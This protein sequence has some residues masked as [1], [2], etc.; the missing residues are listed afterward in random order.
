[1]VN[2]LGVILIIITILYVVFRLSK[3]AMT[4]GNVDIY[5]IDS[6]NKKDYKKYL[7]KN[8]PIVIT[9]Y[10]TEFPCFEILCLEVLRDINADVD[11]KPKNRVAFSQIAKMNI[12]EYIKSIDNSSNIVY[13]EYG[14]FEHYTFD[15]IIDNYKSLILDE[16]FRYG[17]NIFPNNFTTPVTKNQDRKMLIL[18]YDGEILLNILNPLNRNN[19]KL[20]D[21]KFIT[22]D[23]SRLVLDDLQ[24]LE[25]D[26]IK[27]LCRPSKIVLIP[28]GWW[29]YI[30]TIKPSVIV[31]LCENG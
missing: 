21:L 11:V 30:E 29:Y 7:K 31:K 10:L 20:S 15:K 1:M 22:L 13:N 12:G 18:I 23:N 17:L 14:F 27:I 2:S 9:N 24:T 8:Q 4:A 6:F 3:R 25:L 28:S 16:D 19:N 5:Q 26:P